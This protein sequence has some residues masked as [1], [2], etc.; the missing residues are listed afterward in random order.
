MEAAI[1]PE[2]WHAKQLTSGRGYGE[3]WVSPYRLRRGQNQSR[4]RRDV[5]LQ[6]LHL[7]RQDAAVGE[8]QVLG[9]VRDVGGVEELHARLFRQAVPLVAVAVPAG[10]HHVHPGVPAAARKR[11][12]VVARQA[13]IVEL[14]AAVGAHVAVAAEEL[15]I[16]EGRNL[17]EALRGKRLALHR[18]DRM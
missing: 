6:E 16:V 8:D 9:L 11:R 5:L 14:A 1:A 13:K 15:S 4:M 17:V 3:T 10:A 12:D 7:V 2:I 18:D